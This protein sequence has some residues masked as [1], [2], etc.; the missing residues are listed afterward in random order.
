MTNTNETEIQDS[1][2]NETQ[3]K[4]F[5]RKAIIVIAAIATV[6]II[7]LVMNPPLGFMI[8]IIVFTGILCAIMLFV[9][10]RNYTKYQNPTKFFISDEGIRILTPQTKL[11]EIKWAEIGSLKL[12]VIG[13]PSPLT[14]A[15][16]TIGAMSNPGVL[17]A[18]TRKLILKFYKGEPIKRNTLKKI[19]IVLFNDAEIN[20]IVHLI[21]DFASKMK[22]ETVIDKYT[23]KF[24][25]L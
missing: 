7:F 9:L 3:R 13:V 17:V 1:G 8:Y 2:K 16:D 14:T 12:T 15:A 6:N 19:G 18:Q 20:K 10:Y 25:E 24:Y 22:K 21:V 5:Q 11:F 4:E 23:K